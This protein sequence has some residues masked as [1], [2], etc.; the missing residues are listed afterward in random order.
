MES[1]DLVSHA[2][3]RR[4]GSPRPQR[5]PIRDLRDWLSRVERMGELVRVAQPVDRDEEMS[6]IA[7]LLAKQRPS[8][9][10]VFERARG[11]ERS[12]IGANLLWNILGPSLRR[13]ALTLEEPPDTPTIELIRRVKEKLKRRIEPREVSGSE[14]PVYENSLIGRKVDLD[15]LPVP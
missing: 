6:A 3:S 15:R 2:D 4:T 11:F 7:Y 5:S 10:V 12:P 1:V 13:T 9:A 8:P 14:A